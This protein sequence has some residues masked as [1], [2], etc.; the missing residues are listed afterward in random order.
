MTV[1]LGQSELFSTKLT[2][3]QNS[4][5]PDEKHFYTTT[6]TEGKSVK[7]V[8]DNNKVNEAHVLHEHSW[9]PVNSSDIPKEI[10][11]CPAEDLSS[12]LKI[13]RVVAT[14]FIDSSSYKLSFYVRLRGGMLAD[15][16]RQ[17]L[18]K[19]DEYKSLGADMDTQLVKAHASPFLETNDGIVVR[20]LSGAAGGALLGG[21][22]GSAVPVVGTIIG[23]CV[24]AILGG[25]C[26]YHCAESLQ[27]EAKEVGERHRKI[28]E[29][30]VRI[31][32]ARTEEI[33]QQ[34]VRSREI[35]NDQMRYLEQCKY[36]TWRTNFLQ[37]NL[38]EI[39]RVACYYK[40]QKQIAFAIKVV[41]LLSASYAHPR[42]TSHIS[43]ELEELVTPIPEDMPESFVSH[44][45]AILGRLEAEEGHFQAAID[46][47]SKIPKESELAGLV[48]NWIGV[49]NE[50]IE[51]NQKHLS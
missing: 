12:L 1:I 49:C 36:V 30:C 17:A 39:E 15:D 37:L 50:K 35:A 21:T 4:F 25:V 14:R 5:C 9:I 32:E 48:A 41:V 33:N 16:P 13:G 34:P 20:T 45:L 29:N 42:P 47:L 23:A 26:A 46:V 27:Q 10:K 31:H 3:P 6:T 44:C 11:G 22:L 24:G 7:F 8:I 40:D 43:K 51:A 19:V 28:V 2:P 38:P 18:A